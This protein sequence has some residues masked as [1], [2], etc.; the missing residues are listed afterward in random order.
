MSSTNPA[1]AS[2]PAPTPSLPDTVAILSEIWNTNA[3]NPGIL[4]RI[5][6]YVKTQLPQSIKNYQT[7]HAERETRKKS[8]ELF[9]DEFTE[10]FLNRNKYF[11]S[12]HSELYFTYHNQVRYALIHEDE[13]HHRILADITA[14]DFL[15][16]TATT[17]A[18][19][20]RIKNK[21]IKSIQSSRDI[22]SAIPESRTIQNVIGLL[23]PALF[24]TRDHAKYFLTI[25]G[26]VLLKKTAPLIYFVPVV[27]KDF[28]KDLGSE[29]YALFGS[30]ANLFSTAF[31][32][33]YYEHQYKDCRLVDIRWGGGVGAGGVGVGGAQVS[34]SSSWSSSWSTLRL[35][36]IPELQASI[37]DIFCVAAHY[38]H[39][40]GSADDFLRLH[41]KTPDVT[42]HA[43]FLRDR[44]E[45]Q[46]IDEFMDYSTEPASSDHEISMT[47]MMYLWKMYLS[48][49][50]LP[51][52]F[53]AATLRSKLSSASCST[54]AD[55][56]PNRTSKYL[57]LVSQ[58]RQFW[59]ENC[60]TDDREIELE[61]DELS[62]LFNEYASVASSTSLS[63]VAPVNDATLLGMLRHFYPDVIIEDDKYILNVGC[64]IW[65]K[66][67]EINEYLLQFKELCITN[68]HSFPQP[69]YNA[70]E[71]YCGKCY[72]TAKRRII[73]KRYFEKYFMEEYPDY[74]DENGMITIKWWGVTDDDYDA[75][76]AD[77]A[78]DAATLS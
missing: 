61:I 56:I 37:I 65:N 4:E 17:S 36:N 53:F 41:C 42:R 68:H 54:S 24:H 50:R 48:E 57:P 19:K 60:F 7:A 43:W 47:N 15:S 40:F 69:L 75:D 2:V 64:K 10:S 25:L 45:Q 49:F 3:A 74:I 18:T 33:K 26:D 52:V 66:T 51:S 39:R 67:A 44:T 31:K 72:A 16:A 5:H 78:D 77:D 32:F 59:S 29:C 63:T 21:V 8:L 62:T 28:I 70:Y 34:M 55:V 6:T 35:S 12:P 38:S 9:A 23:Y 46:I 71:F 76:D 1:P 11:Y 30:T 14:S 27:A 73:S 20:Y 13:I 58:F 22:L